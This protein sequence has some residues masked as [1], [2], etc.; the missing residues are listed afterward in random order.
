MQALV[1]EG[2]GELVYRGSRKEPQHSIREGFRVGRGHE[3]PSVR[4][5]D[6]ADLEEHLRGVVNVLEDLRRDDRVERFAVEWKGFRVSKADQ[7]PI[8]SPST[9]TGH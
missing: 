1:D 4:P 8:G 9:Q 7:D 3:K 6:A 2:R 5:E